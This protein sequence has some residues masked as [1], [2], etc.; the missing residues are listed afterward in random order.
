MKTNFGPISSLYVGQSEQIESK[1]EM[2]SK[3]PTKFSFDQFNCT[4]A[5]FLYPC[6]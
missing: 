2:V 6:V 3:P 4:Y 1:V 5:V